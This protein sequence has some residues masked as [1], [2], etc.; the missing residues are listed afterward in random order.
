MIEVEIEP[1]LFIGDVEAARV[2]R[3]L[4]I[5]VLNA[6][7]F[8]GNPGA[9]WIPVI[10]ADADNLAKPIQALPQNLDIITA[11]IDRCR[12]RVLV[13]CREA[14]ERSPLAVVWWLRH[15][16]GLSLDDAYALVRERRSAVIDRRAWLPEAP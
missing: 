13:H 2:F 5:C 16:R 1:G 10:A 12:G 9:L 15:S 7:P 3:G 14:R 8:D 11:E 6:W 4:V